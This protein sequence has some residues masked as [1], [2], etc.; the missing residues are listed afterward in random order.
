[1]LRLAAEHE[2]LI[3]VEEGSIGGFAAHVM[4]CLAQHGVFDAGL[5]FRPMTLPDLFIDQDSPRKMYD[6]ARLNAPHIVEMAL[7]ALGREAV[8]AP[9]RA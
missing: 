4:Q 7:A 9:I 2:V 6:T 5:T 1:V 8:E 3:T